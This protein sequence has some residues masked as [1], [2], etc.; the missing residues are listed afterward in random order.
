MRAVAYVTAAA[1]D[2]ARRH[3]DAERAQA[4][5]G[6]RR[7]HDPDRQGL[8]DRDRR[9]RSPRSACRCTAAWAS[10]RRPAP[11]ST[12]ATRGSSTI[13]EGTTGIQA[14]DLIGRKTARDGGAVGARGRRRDRQGRGASSRRTPMRR[15]RRSAC[16]S[17]RR[18][19]RLQSAI[20]W[21][22]PAYGSSTRARA[23]RRGAVP[24]AVGTRRRRLAAGPRRAGR[25]ASSS[26]KATATPRSCARRSR[27]RASTPTRC[28]RRRGLAHAIT[29]GGESA[30]ALPAEQF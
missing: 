12:I 2:N 29:D 15:C 13:Y 28:C 26:P 1:I 17:R 14:N 16:S 24:Q 18:P 21:M 4:P 23:R 11:R 3:P 30:L 20:D 19:P 27:R 22:V 6:V 5:P 25:G 7:L 9:R 8:V 10:S